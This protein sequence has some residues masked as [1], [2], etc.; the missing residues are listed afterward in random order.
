MCGR[1]TLPK[2]STKTAEVFSL[3][4]DVPPEPG[5]N[6]ASTQMVCFVNV[7]AGAAASTG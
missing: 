2:P 4:E 3:V 5:Y 1:Y 6:I 7:L